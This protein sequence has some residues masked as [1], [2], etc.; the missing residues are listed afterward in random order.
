MVFL[1]KPFGCRANS[2]DE[3][4][5]DDDDDDDDDDGR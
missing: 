4:N 3:D 1:F 5:V 2:S